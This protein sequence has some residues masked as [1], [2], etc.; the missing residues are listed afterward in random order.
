MRKLLVLLVVIILAGCASAAPTNAPG[1]TITPNPNSVA[2]VFINYYKEFFKFSADYMT[3][4]NKVELTK[5]VFEY[6]NDSDLNLIVETS[7]GELLIEDGTSFGLALSA[8]T[9]ILMK[10]D[11][12]LPEEIDEVWFIQRNNDL[13]IR[14]EYILDWEVLMDY[15]EYDIT[16]DQMFEALR[17]P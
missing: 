7:S 15:V 9:A 14:E 6:D 2:Y 17:T 3:A 12:P 5:F 1:P 8:L 16:V 4:S 10:Y 11:L 13:V